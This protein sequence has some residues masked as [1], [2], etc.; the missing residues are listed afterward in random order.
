MK[1]SLHSPY[2]PYLKTALLIVQLALGFG[3]PTNAQAG[4]RNPLFPELVTPGSNYQTDL[5]QGYLM[6]YSATNQFDDGGLLYYAHSSYSIYTRDGKFFKNVENHISLSDEIPAV[7]MLPAG[8]YTIEARSEN[9]GY[10]RVPIVITAGR[11]TILDPDKEQTDV[12][13]L[14]TRNKHSRGLA[15]QRSSR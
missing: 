15:D 3:A 10:V 2:S 13:R 7:V 12:Q 14:L 1:S 9:R 4:D 5:P 8:S 11:R 6:V